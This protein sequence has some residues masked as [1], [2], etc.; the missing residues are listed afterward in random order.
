MII[1]IPPSPFSIARHKST[2]FGCASMLRKIVEP[3]EVIPEVASKTAS[4]TVLMSPLP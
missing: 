4:Y 1:P 2:D 3:V